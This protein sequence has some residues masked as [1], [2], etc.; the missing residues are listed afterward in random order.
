MGSE[1]AGGDSSVRAS[2]PVNHST[3]WNLYDSWHLG[4]FLTI[5]KE[6]SSISIDR[7][8]L[9]TV[10]PEGASNYILNKVT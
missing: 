9:I 7:L 6:L 3:L 8:S 5:V 10:I 2:Y 1:S 4:K